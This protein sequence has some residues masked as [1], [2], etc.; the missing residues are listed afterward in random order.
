MTQV[1]AESNIYRVT[2]TPKSSDGLCALYDRPWTLQRLTAKTGWFGS[3]PV[4]WENLFQFGDA[5]MAEELIRKYEREEAARKA[6]RE[7][8][9]RYFTSSPSNP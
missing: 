9:P 3:E 2:P 7:T 5:A 4:F 1:S 6:Y 8:P